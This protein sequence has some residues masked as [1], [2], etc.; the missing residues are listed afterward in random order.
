MIKLYGTNVWGLSLLTLSLPSESVYG[1]QFFDDKL[2][3]F[4]L[5]KN[6]N[7]VRDTIIYFCILIKKKRKF[8]SYPFVA[9][10]YMAVSS[11]MPNC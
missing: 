2:L 10:Q 6:S 5:F 9:N 7:D 1:S 3:Q 4:F 8:S 11:L